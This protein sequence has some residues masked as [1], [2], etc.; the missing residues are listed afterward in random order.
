MMVLQ[1]ALDLYFAAVLG[2]SGLT[3]AVRPHRFA[4]ILARQRI[5]PTWSIPSTSRVFP[6]VEIVLAGALI[7]GLFPVIIATLV[8]A[9]FIVFLCV[10]V[11]LLKAGRSTE[12]GCYGAM[13]SQK[14]STASAATS[15]L[16]VCLAALH[17]WSAVASFPKTWGETIGLWRLVALG[18]FCVTGTWLLYRRKLLHDKVRMEVVAFQDGDPQYQVIDQTG[19][20]SNMGVPLG[21]LRERLGGDVGELTDPVVGK[22]HRISLHQWADA[23]PQKTMISVSFKRPN[24]RATEG[25]RDKASR[26]SALL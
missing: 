12:C 9:L 21:E 1:F 24:R 8:L 3:K 22:T 17:L 11:I 26:H 10:E 23:D 6:W 2:I 18:V 14:V 20:I 25:S 16:L 19:Q 7:A 4:T 13:Y 5:L 15:T